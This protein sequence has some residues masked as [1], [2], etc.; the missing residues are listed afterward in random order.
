MIADS[1]IFRK[2]GTF[3]DLTPAQQ[4]KVK[5]TVAAARRSGGFVWL[6]MVN[7]TADEM[8][9]VSADL[10][11]H[12]LAAADIIGSRQQPKVQRYDQHVFIV[13]WSLLY[14]DPRVDV[15]LGQ[16]FIV[17]GE[18]FLLTV[19][20]TQPDGSTP[21]DLRSVL[22]DE[23]RT[24]GTPVSLAYAVMAIIAAGYTEVA[25]AIEIE[26]EELETQVFD[27]KKVDE[28]Q[29]IYRLRRKIGKVDR[30]SSSLA[31]ALQSA[32]DHFD[33]LTMDDEDVQPY[34]RDLR[35]DL[36][37][38]ATLT[39]N[40]SAAL[41]GVVSSHEN[42]VAGQQ[43]SDT[44]KISAL[45][46]LLAISTVTAGLYGMNFK[47]L[48]GVDWS[49]GWGVTLGSIVLLDIWAFIVFKRRKWL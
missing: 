15:A 31:T 13:M 18:G 39:T 2:T 20:R 17:L 28:P 36:V 45:A 1:L 16:M 29:R 7:P 38:T 42:N 48:P 34:L 8:Q 3:A 14:S 40:Q 37:G 5:A 21:L 26:L 23:A 47:N 11:L 33:R 19:Q 41:D 44:R 32:Q 12:P 22:A 35:D 25:D 4:E 46:A 6:N 27:D 30:A 43:N 10:A 9:S 49:F 24:T